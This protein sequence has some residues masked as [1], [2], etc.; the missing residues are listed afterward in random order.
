MGTNSFPHTQINKLEI[1]V[2]SSK[3][4]LYIACLLVI[5][6]AEHGV[7]LNACLE[8]RAEGGLALDLVEAVLHVLHSAPHGDLQ[9]HYYVY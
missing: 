8:L 6:V 7:A 4:R 9:Q 2:K 1:I 5:E 3:M